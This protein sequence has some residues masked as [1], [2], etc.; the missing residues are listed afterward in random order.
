M[1]AQVTRTFSRR[2]STSE[3]SQKPKW[4]QSRARTNTEG[5]KTN[6]VSEFDEVRTHAR[7]GDSRAEWRRVWLSDFSETIDLAARKNGGR[8]SS[9]RSL[10]KRIG[11]RR[12]SVVR[13]THCSHGWYYYNTISCVLVESS[14]AMTTRLPRRGPEM[15]LTSLNGSREG[16]K[17]DSRYILRVI[18]KW[19]F[20]VRQSWYSHHFYTSYVSQTSLVVEQFVFIDYIIF[21]SINISS[22]EWWSWRVFFFFRFWVKQ[23]RSIGWQNVQLY[24]IT[25]KTISLKNHLFTSNS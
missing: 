14:V 6:T 3:V 16:W 25:L 19:T 18:S 23:K 7:R 22:D 9:R 2:S 17:R 1:F 8:H 24:N 5:N 10:W 21:I 20:S 4:F 13:R 15:G 12:R 11:R